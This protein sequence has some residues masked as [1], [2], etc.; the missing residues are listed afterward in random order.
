MKVTGDHSVPQRNL[1]L[2]PYGEIDGVFQRSQKLF[3]TRG[4]YLGFV[5]GQVTGD[6]S[7]FTE[8][9]QGMR[10]HWDIL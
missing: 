7:E 9:F 6:I 10:G 5:L 4:G 1:P 8:A 3:N 2:F